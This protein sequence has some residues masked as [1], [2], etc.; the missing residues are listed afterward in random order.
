MGAI[1]STVQLG[2]AYCCC[3]TTSSLCNTCLG[4][5]SPG[6]TGRKRSVLLFT[7]TITF[8]LL[9]QYS[10]AP[11][12]INQNGWWKIYSSIPGLGKQ[13]YTSWT[14][15]CEVYDQ[16]DTMDLFKQ[17]VANAG[18]Y[19]PT[20]VS[21][22]FFLISAIATKT[23][24][25]LNREGWPA[26]FGVYLLLVAITMFIPNPLF[27][28]FYLIILRLCAMAFIIIQQVILIDM[29]YNWNESWVERSNE[30]ESREWGSGKVW[31]RAILG[32]SVFL[33]VAAL[34]GIILLYKFFTECTENTVVI[35]L[36]WVGIVIITGAQLSG[37]EGSLLTTAVISAYSTYLA[38]S[39][40][41]K[42]PNAVCNPTL[43]GD[44]IWGIVLGLCFTM[45]S[46]IWT[47]WSWTAEERLNAEGLETTRS[48]TPVN[49][50]NPDPATLDLDV[51]FLDP[52]ERPTTG[53]VMQSEDN[54][55]PASS[56]LWK[57]N[58]ILTLISCW[59]AAS[60]TGWGSISGGIGDDGEHTAANP[61]VGRLNMAMIAV[62]QNV[63]VLLYL[64][65]LVAP[66]MFPD[67]EFS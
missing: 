38:Y 28:G 19:R 56:S 58:V 13:M 32:M 40:V 24:P 64:W 20:F 43:G 18:V 15:G 35:S 6:T 48:L 44:D 49:P 46:L 14:N 22:L 47:G 9:F 66:R 45:V 59:V 11:S 27:T 42:N 26:K 21:T 67:R 34:V 5:T 1:A 55:A 16:E 7:L 3:N 39:I 65:T 25:R 8:A 36:T 2:L 50:S 29:A 63:A 12:V 57:L 23:N 17:C 53:V 62:S 33:Y 30:C 4:S 60:L 37:E 10:L 31:L 52:E 51:P 54:D 41:S 61:L